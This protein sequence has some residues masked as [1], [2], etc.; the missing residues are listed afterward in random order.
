MIVSSLR[1]PYAICSYDF[2]AATSELVVD[3]ARLMALKAEIPN[4][5]A[6]H[7]DR[8]GRRHRRD[9]REFGV[10][11]LV[12]QHHDAGRVDPDGARLS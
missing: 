11:T 10:E 2:L 1:R 6:L 4:L 3:L 5:T 9:T 8:L 7:G 12:N